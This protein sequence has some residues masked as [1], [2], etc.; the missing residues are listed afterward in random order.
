[1][2]RTGPARRKPFAER[3]DAEKRRYSA[4]ALAEL[5]V[6]DPRLISEHRSQF[7]G[8]SIW[9]YTEADGGKWG[10]RYRSA[11]AISDVR[12][13]PL[14]HEHVVPI[15]ALVDRMLESPER[16]SEIMA[17][18]VACLVTVDEH[19][20]LHA[21]EADQPAPDLRAPLNELVRWGWHRYQT[22][23]IEVWDMGNQTPVDLARLGQ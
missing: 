6:G 7:L 20:R 13:T 9:K 2:S 14:N 19:G 22:A 16:V 12:G 21:A 4:V 10:T 15:K 17:V 3:T 8:F 5:L 18:A 1:M 11:G 23:G